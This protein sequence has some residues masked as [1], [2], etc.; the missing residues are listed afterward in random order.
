MNTLKLEFNDFDDTILY[1]KAINVDQVGII[2]K[3]HDKH[4]GKDV[5][6]YISIRI[7]N[8]G[9]N[10]ILLYDTEQDRDIDYEYAIKQL[11]I[12]MNINREEF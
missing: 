11:D 5:F 9:D 2:R 6:Y 12:L 10:Y 3:N 1:L 7:N 8:S 4:P